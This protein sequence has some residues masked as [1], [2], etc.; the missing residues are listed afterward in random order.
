LSRKSIDIS[1]EIG[2]RLAAV[3]YHVKPER[4]ELLAFLFINPVDLRSSFQKSCAV[5][6]NFIW[7]K[8]ER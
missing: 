1:F 8:R 3:K 2:F 5:I 6:E 7:K 4:L